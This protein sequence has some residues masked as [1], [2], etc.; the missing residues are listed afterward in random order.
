MPTS[1]AI[2][3]TRQDPRNASLEVFEQSKKLG[4]KAAL[5]FSDP[6]VVDRYGDDFN[7]L[8][9]QYC[10][11]VFCNADEARQFA[12]VESLE[13]AASQLGQLVELVFITDG[14]NGC[15]VIENGRSSHVDGFEV[16]AVDTVGAGDAFAGGVLYGLAAG[17]TAAEAARWGNYLASR[18]V[19]IHGARLPNPV[20]DEV[21]KILDA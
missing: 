13:E 4:V 9:K 3:G 14:P 2:C 18:V 19:T 10:D 11:V 6:F 20:K 15:I 21:S 7:N 8:A 1:R 5:T 12:G 17:R 16:K